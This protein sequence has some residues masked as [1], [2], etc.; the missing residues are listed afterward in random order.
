[1]ATIV[2]KGRSPSAL[3]SLNRLAA[4]GLAVVGAW[5]ELRRERNQLLALADRELHDI[6]ISRV[7][8]VSAAQRSLWREALARVGSR[9]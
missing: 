9:S 4:Q 8:A 2:L 6:G 7:D 1:M 5:L 3:A